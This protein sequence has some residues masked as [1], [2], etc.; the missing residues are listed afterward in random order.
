[1]TTGN[2]TIA[3]AGVHLALSNVQ[4]IAWYADYHYSDIDTSIRSLFV[5]SP[6]NYLDV[7]GTL[8]NLKPGLSALNASFREKHDK[9]ALE[10]ARYMVNLMLLS[11]K[12]SKDNVLGKQVSTTLDMLEDAASDLDQQRDYIIE[13]IAQLYQN[14]LSKINPRII[15]YGKPEFLNNA[16]NAATI[17]TLLLS[18]LRSALLWYQAGGGQLNLLLGKA[19]YLKTIDQMLA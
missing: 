10:R 8:E 2:R 12:L 17:R 15:V 7:Y 5:R 14:T 3:L 16:D 4:R 13:K 18:G 9:Q 19:K 1:M 6:E 11:K